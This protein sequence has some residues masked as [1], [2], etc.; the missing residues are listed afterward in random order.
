VQ[1]GQAAG[2]ERAPGSLAR[3][4]ALAGGGP[5]LMTTAR[6]GRSPVRNAAYRLRARR[7]DLHLKLSW[8]LASYA[9]LAPTPWQ[10]GS[11]AHEQGVSKAGNPRLRT[12]MIQLAWLWLRHQ[13]IRRWRAGS[14]HESNAM[15]DAC[16]RRRLSRSRAKL[17]VALWKYVTAGVVIEGAIVKRA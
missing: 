6:F 4:A 3:F 16:G 8:R 13:R 5:V 1:P 15:V 7:P 9:G 10:S 2:S 11:V 12:T 17:L 14:M